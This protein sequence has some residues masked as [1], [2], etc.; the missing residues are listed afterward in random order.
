MKPGS[1]A[2]ALAI[3]VVLSTAAVGWLSAAP[4]DEGQPA[5]DLSEYVRM[6]ESLSGSYVQQ[7]TAPPGGVAILDKCTND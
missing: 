4:G 6:H 2:V 5:A 3:A 7:R 1:R